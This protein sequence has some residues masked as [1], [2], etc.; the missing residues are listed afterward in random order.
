MINFIEKMPCCHREGTLIVCLLLVMSVDVVCG[1]PV[2]IAFIIPLFIGT[3]WKGNE[4]KEYSTLKIKSDTV[5][6]HSATVMELI[7]KTCT[8]AWLWLPSFILA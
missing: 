5:K 7:R 3:Y 6:Y 8:K 2:Q 4:K 1:Q